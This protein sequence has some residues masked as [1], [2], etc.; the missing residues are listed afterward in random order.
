MLRTAKMACEPALL[1]LMLLH[2][3]HIGMPHAPLRH[4]SIRHRVIQHAFAAVIIF[5]AVRLSCTRCVN[6]V[7][8]IQ[9]SIGPVEQF[10]VEIQ[11]A[12]DHHRYSYL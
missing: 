3:V 1:I 7:D 4:I 2:K 11:N 5:A 12:S 10:A 8:C 6:T 9:G